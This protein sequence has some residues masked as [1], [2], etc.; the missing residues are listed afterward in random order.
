MYDQSL[1]LIRLI[2]CPLLCL[3]R[4]TQRREKGRDS[5]CF[6]QTTSGCNG[7][8][9]NR[10]HHRLYLNVDG[11]SRRLG[12]VL[13]CGIALWSQIVCTHSVISALSRSRPPPVRNLPMASCGEV[14]CKQGLCR[15]STFFKRTPTAPLV[16]RMAA[17]MHIISMI[18][19]DSQLLYLIGD[20]I[21]DSSGPIDYPLGRQQTRFSAV[22]PLLHG[23][24]TR[25]KKRLHFAFHMSRLAADAVAFPA[26]PAF[27]GYIAA[28][29]R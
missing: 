15:G 14:G 17:Y 25:G 21:G 8:E 6:L 27:G 9:R 5:I 18:R 23:M 29:A 16:V 20:S 24:Y 1:Q 2:M 10:L 22:L 13:L 19:S 11:P 28:G 12:D 4:R 3:R 7:S 26:A